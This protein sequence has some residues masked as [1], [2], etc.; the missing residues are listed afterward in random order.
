VQLTLHLATSVEA[1]SSHPLAAA[2]LSEGLGCVTTSFQNGGPKSG[3]AQVHKGLAS[4]FSAHQ[5]GRRN[6][7]THARLPIKAAWYLPLTNVSGHNRC[8]STR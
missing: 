4:Y 2:V 6:G 3:L 8:T 5:S 7:P 1:L